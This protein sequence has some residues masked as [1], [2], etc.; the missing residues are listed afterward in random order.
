MVGNKHKRQPHHVQLLS[1][2]LNT[3]SPHPAKSLKHK[4]WARP[5]P[6]FFWVNKAPKS[7]LL[8]LV[9]TA[10]GRSHLGNLNTGASINLCFHSPNVSLGAPPQMNEVFFLNNNHNSSTHLGVLSDPS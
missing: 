10:N 7:I 5:E 4:Q 6:L 3:L 1:Q 2:Q 9:S 8:V